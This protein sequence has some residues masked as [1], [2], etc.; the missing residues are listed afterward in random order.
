VGTAALGLA[1]A[2]AGAVSGGQLGTL[3]GGAAGG[4]LSKAIC[5]DDKEECKK[6]CWATLE[7]DEAECIVAKAG[8]GTAAQAICLG[9]AKEYYSQC[10]R[11]C[12]GK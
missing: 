5:A 9:K 8:Y 10:L 3:L 4:L 1:G 12:D 6:D 7:R 11:K 2:Q